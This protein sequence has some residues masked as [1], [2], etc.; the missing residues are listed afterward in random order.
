MALAGIAEQPSGQSPSQADTQPDLISCSPLQGEHKAASDDRR[1]S[2]I[3]EDATSVR[4]ADP[5]GFLVSNHVIS[6]VFA[7]LSEL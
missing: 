7:A 3:L 4:L 5:D 1:G 2:L 6:D